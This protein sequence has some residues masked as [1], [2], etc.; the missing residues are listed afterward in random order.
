MTK[1]SSGSVIV[2]SALQPGYGDVLAMIE[3]GDA[4]LLGE[5]YDSWGVKEVAASL[6]SL[7]PNA[8]QIRIGREFFTT[9]LRD[10]QD[11]RE[12]WWRE[13]VQNAVDA[14]AT[15]VICTVNDITTS[16]GGR[17]VEVSA[18]DNGRGMDEDTLLNKFLVLGGTTKATASGTTGGF[19]KAKE[20]LVLPWLAWSVHT[21]DLLVEGSGVEYDVRKASY[22]DGTKLTVVM[23]S[24]QATNAAAATSFIKKCLIPKVSFTV[25]GVLERADLRPGKEIRNFDGKA[26][27][28]H[29]KKSVVD[30]ILVRANGIYMFDIY[31]SNRVEGSLIMELNRPSIELLTAN[32]D[33]FRDSS[34]RYE[35][36]D[37]SNQLAADIKS[38]L[39]SKQG[40][41]R[42]KFRGTGQFSSGVRGGDLESAIIEAQ[43]SFV[44]ESKMGTALSAEQVTEI[45]VVLQRALGHTSASDEEA[46]T[47]FAA[48]ADLARAMLT[49]L[50]VLGTS[51][52]EAA[53]RQLSWEPDFYLVN[54][55]EGWRVSAKFKPATM[56]KRLKQLLRFWAELCRFVLIQLSS[57][58]RYGVGFIFSEETNAS[59]IYEDGEHW[60]MLNPLK[61]S[62]L[63]LR[64][65]STQDTY[66]LSNKR[67]VDWLYAAAVHECTHIADGIHYHDEA[68]SSA[69][70]ANV[71]KTASGHRRIAALKKAVV[72]KR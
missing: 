37:F 5:R 21:R 55:I 19:G 29:N 1:R 39:K 56:Q 35:V 36:S 47:N 68:F 30:G 67:D 15:A 22:L 48:T 16:A 38:A 7:R 42:E 71:A 45:A 13:A 44:P 40:L 25:N 61:P 58:H 69:F 64:D 66:S 54:E 10:Y 62:Q 6:G 8:Q 2:V 14:H 23:P 17:A 70:T 26:T 12:K 4:K 50:E 63:G 24:D 59:Y 65:P 11:W 9:A 3:R 41:I 57:A 51:Q 20:L 43:V 34:L 49:G 32:R 53:A 18:E 52:M 46:A 28:Y 33:G 60:L 72:S 31:V 27:L